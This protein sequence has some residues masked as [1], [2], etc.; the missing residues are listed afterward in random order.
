M[1]IHGS[2]I[3]VVSSLYDLCTNNYNIDCTYI[4]LYFVIIRETLILALTY[5]LLYTEKLHRLCCCYIIIYNY[6]VDS[7][8]FFME[9][10]KASCW[11]LA[12]TSLFL[13]E[14]TQTTTTVL[15]MKEYEDNYSDPMF[16]IHALHALHY[17]HAEIFKF[18]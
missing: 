17:S 18:N 9:Q 6:T 3:H 13:S 2:N 16:K 12:A 14:A 11:I 1:Y 8:L 15:T 5:L 10:I 7:V 4:I